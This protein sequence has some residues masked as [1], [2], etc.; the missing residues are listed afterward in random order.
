MEI[1]ISC[2]FTKLT[3]KY[4][5]SNTFEPLIV[6]AMRCVYSDNTLHKPRLLK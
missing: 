2:S 1:I 6:N 4:D 3:S 5:W